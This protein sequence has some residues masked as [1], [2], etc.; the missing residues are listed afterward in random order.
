MPLDSQLAARNAIDAAK[1]SLEKDARKRLSQGRAREASDSEHDGV[2]ETS[3]RLEELSTSSQDEEKLGDHQADSNLRRSSVALDVIQRKGQYGLFVERWFSKKGW[4]G[5]RETGTTVAVHVEPKPRAGQNDGSLS[6]SASNM[7]GTILPKLLN[8]LRVLLESRS[9]FYSYDI[10]IS[11]R[12]GHHEKTVSQIPLHKSFDPDF[13]WNRHLLL[14]L[15][16][17]GQPGFVLPLIQG[18]VGQRAFVIDK[19]FEY[20]ASSVAS[21][22]AGATTLTEIQEPLDI[23]DKPTTYLV[24]LMSRRSIKRPGLR[25][26]RR[27]IDEDGHCAN[28]VETEQIL[29]CTSPTKQYSFTQ[30]RASIPLFF[31]Q[32]PYAFKPI[33]VL[34]HSEEANMKACRRHFANLKS[35][36]GNVQ[37]TLLVD[38][39]GGE[40]E[41]GQRYEGSIERLNTSADLMDHNI[42]FQWFD[43]H[44]Q[45]RGMKFENVSLLMSTLGARLDEFGETLEAE[46]GERRG[47][48]GVLRTNCMDCLDRT[49][50]GKFLD[51]RGV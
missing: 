14:P 22:P 23:H 20:S 45:C 25:Y 48:T 13:F 1:K 35:R 43:F 15:I 5:I 31:S 50:V 36:Y 28:T 9:F 33:P 49:N 44:A 47:Q 12:I 19:R 51:A 38:K 41:I 6:T 2:Y 24:T 3:D 37:V 21:A 10:D 16:D 32:S 8:T 26:L 4:Q 29:S 30:L 11:R 7:A 18:F 27:G 42:G 40:S 17:S 34:Q 39:A 46:A